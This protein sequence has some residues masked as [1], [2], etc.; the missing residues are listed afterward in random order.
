M[1]YSDGGGL[2]AEERARRFRAVRPGHRLRLTCRVH[3]SR[4]SRGD[5]RK[6]FTETDYARPPG[7]AHQQLGGP[8]VV[9]GDNRAGEDPA[10]AVAVPAGPPRRLPRRH[11]AR[12]HVLP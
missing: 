12:P 5:R 1:R 10:Q 8:L 3:A 2:T 4:G 11:R 9:V 7:A 6:G